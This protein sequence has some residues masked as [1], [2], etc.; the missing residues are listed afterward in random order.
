MSRERALEIMN[1]IEGRGYR[2]YLVGG[3]VRDLLLGREPEDWD[4][5]SSAQPEQI[6][7]IFGEDAVPTGV[8]HGTVT[9]KSAG[10][11]YEVTTF[12]TEGRYS[13]GRHPDSVAFAQTVEEDLSRRDFTV[14]AMAMD[15]SGNIIDPFGGAEDLKRQVIRCVG[16]A[17]VR[18]SEDAL[19]IL[20]GIRFAAVLGF[21]VEEDT[22]RAIHEQAGLLE[23]I[24]AERILAEMDKLLCG[25]GCREVLLTYADVVGVFIPELLP[26]VGFDQKNR[27]HCYTLYEHIVQATAAVPAEPVLRWTMLLHDIGKV[28]TFTVDD[29]GQGHFYGHPGVSADMAEEICRRLRMRRQDRE[30][31]VTLI[32]WHDRSIPVTEKGIGS[33]VLELGERNFRRLLQVK[34]ADNLAQAPEF[35]GILEKI[36]RAEELLNRMLS[37][38][39]CLQLK[40]LAVNG[41]DIM[42]LGYSGRAV[43][44]VLQRLLEGVISGEMENRREALLASLT[45]K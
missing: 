18:F 40:D 32:R 30:D 41:K 15:R 37:E 9:V 43:G 5:A 38:K 23:R 45:E 36:D 21:S 10:E 1:T 34:R 39:R 3:C 19:R 16:E 8:K 14:N 35:R 29:G 13:D 25:G 27:H 6:M 11:G 17:R 2:A 42:A 7:E 31:I 28:K 24:A 44:E 26:C 22:Q 20:R 4:I 12:R 33:A